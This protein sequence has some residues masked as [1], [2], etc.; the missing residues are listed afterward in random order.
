MRTSTYSTDRILLTW[1]NFKNIILNEESNAAI[2][3][4][5]YDIPFIKALKMQN[6]TSSCLQIHTCHKSIKARDQI[7]NT[8][9]RII[10]ASEEK[11]EMRME[12]GVQGALNYSVMFISLK[13]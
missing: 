13:N 2:G 7:K 9:F 4:L 1:V 10:A 6:N 12:K 11:G 8:I 3:N 5:Q